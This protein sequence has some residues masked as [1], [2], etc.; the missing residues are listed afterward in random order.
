MLL[1]IRFLFLALILNRSKRQI[2]YVNQIWPS[3]P[4]SCTP[5]RT[6]KYQAYLAA[7]VLNLWL[8]GTPDLFFS[9]SIL[10]HYH[11][12]NLNS[13]KELSLDTLA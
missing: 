8:N 1:T 3:Y 2:S 6:N 9:A 11:L 13:H 10:K 7:L 5:Q 12:R 4:S